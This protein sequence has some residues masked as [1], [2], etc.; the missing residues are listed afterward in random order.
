MLRGRLG[1]PGPL[2]L[3]IGDCLL[4]VL[5]RWESKAD[6]KAGQGDQVM[7]ISVNS[8][9]SPSVAQ[10]RADSGGGGPALSHRWNGVP[11]PSE[12]TPEQTSPVVQHII[13]HVT[14]TRTP[15][16]PDYRKQPWMCV[17][18]IHMYTQPCGPFTA[19]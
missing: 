8:G 3:R 6:R 19:L 18:D 12:R 1:G 13:L 5:S 7:A 15:D 9:L 2:L 10:C 17:L 4:G 11:I 16:Q 14:P